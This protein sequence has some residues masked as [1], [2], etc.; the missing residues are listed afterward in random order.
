MLFRSLPDDVSIEDVVAFLPPIT[1]PDLARQCDI[2]LKRT[3][4]APADVHELHTDV[5]IPGLHLA[6]LDDGGVAKV[7]G[8]ESGVDSGVIN[9]ESSGVEAPDWRPRHAKRYHEA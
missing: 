7:V 8:I 3:V 2:A 5:V 4:G 6:N 9:L 1:S